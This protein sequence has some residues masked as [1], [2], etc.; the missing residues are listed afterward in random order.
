MVMRSVCGWGA[1]LI[2]GCICIVTIFCRLKSPA[3][4][5]WGDIQND[6]VESGGVE[7]I[8]TQ[9]EYQSETAT[10][11]GTGESGFA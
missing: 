5:E 7:A 3:I 10:S 4:R 9:L 6:T 8:P 11:A 1:C 2:I